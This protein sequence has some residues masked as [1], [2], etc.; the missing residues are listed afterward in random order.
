MPTRGKYRYLG[1]LSPDVILKVK[2]AL[3]LTEHALTD[4]TT[5]NTT[6]EG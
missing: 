5:H 6:P 2:C 3:K 1:Q 4:I